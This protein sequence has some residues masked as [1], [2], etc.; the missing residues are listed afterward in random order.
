MGRQAAVR[1]RGAPARIRPG[2]L[3]PGEVT[4]L[5]LGSRLFTGAAAHRAGAP[6][7]AAMVHAG[8]SGA[9]GNPRGGEVRERRARPRLPG[10]RAHAGPGAAAAGEGRGA[11]GAA[12]R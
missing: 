5:R 1:A 10:G 11:A 3:V 7:D 6:T 4:L 8:G 12:P 2:G 9:A